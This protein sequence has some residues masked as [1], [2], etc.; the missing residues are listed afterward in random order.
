MS[1]GKN[2]K[3]IWRETETSLSKIKSSP[4][5]LGF[6]ENIR[7]RILLRNVEQTVT[8]NASFVLVTSI[9]EK[10]KQAL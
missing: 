8:V 10:N 7:P 3:N 6:L 5:L 1:M 2:T 9:G 4:S